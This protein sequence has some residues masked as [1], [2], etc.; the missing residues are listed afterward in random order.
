MSETEPTMCTC[1]SG[2]GMNLSCPVH[3]PSG[4]ARPGTEA[5][6]PERKAHGEYGLRLDAAWL[7]GMSNDGN[8]TAKQSADLLYLAERLR[9]IEAALSPTVPGEGAGELAKDAVREAFA[10]ASKGARASLKERLAKVEY[11]DGFTLQLEDIVSLWNRAEAVAL[12]ALR[13]LTPTVPGEGAGEPSQE[14]PERVTLFLRDRDNRYW[15]NAAAEGANTEFE[16]EPL[17]I[18]VRVVSPTVPAGTGAAPENQ[19]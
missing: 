7:R 2:F 14:A 1:K 4:A 10:E 13:S 6:Q 8:L 3:A 17:G 9:Q 5:A 18:Y 12:T 19:K 15:F 16:G 11:C